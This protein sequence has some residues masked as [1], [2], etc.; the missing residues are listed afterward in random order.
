MLR[1]PRQLSSPHALVTCFTVLYFELL[2]FSPNCAPAPESVN[3]GPGSVDHLCAIWSFF[4]LEV[5][6][7]RCL[8]VPPTRGTAM[9]PPRKRPCRRTGKPSSALP[10]R[11]ELAAGSFSGS[12]SGG[13]V[14]GVRQHGE[15]PQASVPLTRPTVPFQGPLLSW[16]H[17][18]LAEWPGH[19]CCRALLTKTHCD[20]PEFYFPQRA[21]G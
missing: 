4:F 10:F 20:S 5:S 9:L 6:F 18:C 13:G 8:S 19:R 15:G 12:V 2:S 21:S 3:G 11:R 7:S 1:V 17:V 14:S 16:A